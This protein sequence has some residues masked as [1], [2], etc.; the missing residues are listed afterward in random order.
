MTNEPFKR[1]PLCGKTWATREQFLNDDHTRL[2][3]YQCNSKR[4][5]QG[6]PAQGMLVF[7]HYAQECGTTLAL[8]AASF[9]EPSPPTEPEE[10]SAE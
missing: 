3:G 4:L 6:L 10:P 7:T 9:R 2:N 8:P 1:C 5:R